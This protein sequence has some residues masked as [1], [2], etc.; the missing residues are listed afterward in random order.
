MTD[1]PTVNIVMSGHIDHGKSTLIGRLLYDTD[2][3][4]PQLKEEIENTAKELG[5]EMEFAF[6]MDNLEEEREAGIT[7]DTIQT[8]FNSMKYTYNIIDVPGHKEFIKNM[9][10]L[11]AKKLCF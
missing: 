10:I 7:I 1:L 11:F 3:I 6:F 8:L 5:K 2:S 9:I 4:N